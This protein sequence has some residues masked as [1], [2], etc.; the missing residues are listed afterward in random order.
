MDELEVYCRDF[1]VMDK[2]LE[3]LATSTSAAEVKNSLEAIVTISS[4]FSESPA[5]LSAVVSKAA[6]DSMVTSICQ[7][8]Q[9]DANGTVC[10][11][12]ALT[13]LIILETDCVTGA[14]ADQLDSVRSAHCDAET[15]F[16]LCGCG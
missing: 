8:N 11:L 15:S 6:I 12:A 9:T 5:R 4:C 16:V 2:V 10:R 7:N 13:H 14:V 1:R 3:L